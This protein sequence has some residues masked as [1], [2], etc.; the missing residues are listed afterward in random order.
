MFLSVVSEIDEHIRHVNLRRVEVL[1]RIYNGKR[2]GEY[3][4][5]VSDVT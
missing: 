4:M 5:V 3:E 2:K 1:Q